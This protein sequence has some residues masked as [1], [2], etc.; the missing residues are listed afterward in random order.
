MTV[1]L[2]GRA[3]KHMAGRGKEAVEEAGIICRVPD[4]LS[5][6]IDAVRL[7]E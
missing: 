4:D 6:S 5:A 1:R 7:G 2:A 3:R